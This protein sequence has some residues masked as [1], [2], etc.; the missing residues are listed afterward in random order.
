MLPNAGSRRQPGKNGTRS[1][2]ISRPRLGDPNGKTMC[3]DRPAKTPFAARAVSSSPHVPSR[4]LSVR[5]R[6]G[7]NRLRDAL[8]ET[9][10]LDP[11]WR[12]EELEAKRALIPDEEN[13][14]IDLIKARTLLPRRW[15]SW[16]AYQTK[17]KKSLTSDE[18][19][20]L[21]ESF[22]ELEPPLVLNELQASSLRA[23]LK[24]V[25]QALRE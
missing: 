6:I 25:Q 22:L 2:V 21:Q 24:K 9:D 8:A 10:R 13:S 19:H 1:R 4:V 11:G 23:E 3:G 12:L 17:D 20:D 14:A 16:D 7:W 15:P 18:V 5:D